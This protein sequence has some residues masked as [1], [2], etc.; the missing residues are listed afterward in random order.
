MTHTLSLIETVK[1]NLHVFCQGLPLVAPPLSVLRSSKAFDKL[2]QDE[3]QFK[4]LGAL[5]RERYLDAVAKCRYSQYLLYSD[6][7][8]KALELMEEVGPHKNLLAYA[9]KM[10][11]LWCLEKFDELGLMVQRF[12]P[13]RASELEADATILAYECCAIC[14]TVVRKAY[15]AAYAYYHRAEA[16]AIEHGLTYRLAVIRM[17]LEA[18]TNMAGESLV[19]DPLLDADAGDFKLFSLRLTSSPHTSSNFSTSLGL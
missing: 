7:F 15:K 3:Q 19:L 9:I 6:Q 4:R 2:R 5:G 18:A 11:A 12:K 10:K 13:G 16:L 1:K 8:Q 14:Y 17:N